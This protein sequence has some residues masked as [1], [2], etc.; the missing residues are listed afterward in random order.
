MRGSHIPYIT[1]KQS[2]RP[3]M[4]VDLVGAEATSA[5]RHKRPRESESKKEELAKRERTI[6]TMG[7]IKMKKQISTAPLRDQN[8]GAHLQEK[9]SPLMD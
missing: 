2:E 8:G 3:E 4:D 5:V 9:Q 1:W 7:R 6:T